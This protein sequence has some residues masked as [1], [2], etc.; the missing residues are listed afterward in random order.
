MTS[1]VARIPLRQALGPTRTPP[2]NRLVLVTDPPSTLRNVSIGPATSPD[3]KRAAAALVRRMYSWR[4]YRSHGGDAE[5]RIVLVAWAANEAL[6]TLTLGRDS[7]EG[8][9]ADSL[10]REE[11][12]NLRRQQRIV[13]EITRLAAE[14]DHGRPDLLAALFRAAQ[15]YGRTALGATDVVTEV[16]PRHARY[17]QRRFGFS[18]LGSRRHCPRVDAP[19]VLLHREYPLPAP[20]PVLPWSECANESFPPPSAFDER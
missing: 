16:N 11:L 2:A 13:C 3:Q 6:A 5:H 15:A 1:T 12:Q 18:T 7:P 8:L 9:M 19:A 4:G 20:I 17:Y 10:Y 14:P